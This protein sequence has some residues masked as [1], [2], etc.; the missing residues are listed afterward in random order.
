MW[1]ILN[2]YL[3]DTN[4]I[5]HILRPREESNGLALLNWL[6]EFSRNDEVKLF[7]PEVCYYEALRGHLYIKLKYP[8]YKGLDELKELKDALEYLAMTTEMWMLAAKLWAERQFRGTPVGKGIDGDTLLAAQAIL[9]G[10]TIVTYNTRHFFNDVPTC[11]WQELKI[12]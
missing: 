8:S 12:V 7:M 10:C 4:I 5:T 9:A 3:I 1:K 11:T 2:K 6:E